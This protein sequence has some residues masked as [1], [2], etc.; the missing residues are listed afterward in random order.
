MKSVDNLKNQQNI[1]FR[2][3]S[4]SYK[5]NKNLSGL[6]SR[7]ND[8]MRSVKGP[9]PYRIGSPFRVSISK[10][11]QNWSVSI[12]FLVFFLSILFFF[13]GANKSELSGDGVY[14]Y[15]Y[16]LS[17]PHR[18]LNGDLTYKIAIISDLDTE[19]KSKDGDWISHMKMG[20]LTISND[21]RRVQVNE[22]L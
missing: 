17:K 14:N 7:M 18:S 5:K 19:S 10:F 20:W 3:S 8:W 15:T 6:S 12:L 9:N 22:D 16:P 1:R 2:M 13:H 21:M 11:V 4:T